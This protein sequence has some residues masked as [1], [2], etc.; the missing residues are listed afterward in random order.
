[1]HI[2]TIKVQDFR[3]FDHLEMKFRNG[4]N[5]LVGDNA[6]GKTSVLMA[7]RQVLNAFFS[8]FS[9]ENTSWLGLD[10]NDFRQV[11]RDGAILPDKPVRIAF[12]C[13][14]VGLPEGRYFEVVKKSRK[15]GRILV[16]PL[17]DYR[18]Y[19]RQLAVGMYSES[20]DRRL[21][22]PLF[23]FF[24]TE[25]I[26]K[27][28]KVPVG[29]FKEYVHKPSFGYV[30]CLNS[31]GL[32]PH[33][34]SRL[35]VLEENGDTTREVSIVCSAVRRTLG[36]GGCGIIKDI[37]VRP[38]RGKVYCMLKDG[39]EMEVE[40]LSDGHRRLL[41]IVIDLAFRCALLNRTVPGYGDETCIHTKGV[42]LIDEV[43]MHL[44]PGLQLQALPSVKAAFPGLQ[45]IAT[46]HA[47]MVM[48]AIEDNE[49]NIVQ[50]LKYDFDGQTYTASCVSPFGLDATS[51]NR[52]VLDMPA[53]H[54]E[55]EQQL[56]NLFALI[57]DG[58]ETEA[59]HILDTM[60]ERFGSKLPELARAGAML[61][62]YMAGEDE[63]DTQRL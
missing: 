33:W 38:K 7:C 12:S 50:Y 55:V 11:V 27:G 42:V 51:V 34:L 32:L 48:T 56:A 23:A 9:D 59:R 36:E 61:D 14:A 53:R 63:Q 16:S 17:G 19:S 5:L 45:F 28:S 41:G 8:G 58:R 30:E 49:E 3:G 52:L 39:R 46:T 26:H 4:I 54:V 24:S 40:L 6:S 35:L 10:D 31:R 47:P 37:S 44:H 57:D 22:L 43:D 62:F 15:K 25:G 29:K 18:D 1:M 60:R 20:G 13:S 2:D 21:A